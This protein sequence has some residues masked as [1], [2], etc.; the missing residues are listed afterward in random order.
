MPA[1]RPPLEPHAAIKIQHAIN[2]LIGNNFPP[3][4][5][6]VPWWLVINAQKCGTLPFCLWLMARYDNY[7]PA[8][9]FYTAAHG[10]YGIIWLLKHVFIPDDKWNVKT[11]VLSQVFSFLLVLGPYWAA[12]YL[13]MSRAAPEPPFGRC[14]AAMIVY[15]I[16]VVIMCVA[17]CYKSVTLQHKRGLIT[18]GPFAVV[19]HPN[20]LGEMMVYGGFAAMVP[21]WIPKAVLAWVWL[22]VFVPNMMLKEASMYRYGQEWDEY[23]ARTG[24][25]LPPLSALLGRKAHG[26]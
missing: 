12:P 25:L 7:S 6:F 17:D 18:T 9:C 8:A 26:A 2:S 3:G 10:S 19:R 22:Q 13:L 24:M 16:G 1:A 15:V 11:T 4:P 20:Y 5:A 14:C 23:Y 21:H